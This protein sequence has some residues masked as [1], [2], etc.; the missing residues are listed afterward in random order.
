M[1]SNLPARPDYFL[2]DAAINRAGATPLTELPELKPIAAAELSAMLE[3]GAIALDVRPNDRVCRGPRAGLDQRRTLRAVCFVGRG[4]AGIVGRSGADR[5]N[6]RATG[7]GAAS[8]GA[9]WH[10]KS[11]GL[12]RRRARRLAA[13]GICLA[14]VAADHGA[15]TQRSRCERTVCRCSMFVARA[16]GRRDTSTA[17]IGIRWIA[18]KPRCQRSSRSSR[19]P[20]TARAVIAA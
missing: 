15:G 5:R 20:S 16:N 13:G 18:S 9:S 10:R 3:R 17:P 11:G 6:C 12:S 1:T 19:S 2:E 7:R 4:G 8:S 14:A